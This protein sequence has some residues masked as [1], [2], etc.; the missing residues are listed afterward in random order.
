MQPI[1]PE[2]ADPGRSGLI[3]RRDV[4]IGTL[5][6]FASGCGIG[7]RIPGGNIV[8]DDRDTEA[9]SPAPEEP[10]R[11][12]ENLV[13]LAED[14]TDIVDE[15]QDTRFL[16]EVWEND[17]NLNPQYRGAYLESLP[18]DTGEPLLHSNMTLDEF[19]GA[20]ETWFAA[21][22]T[23]VKIDEITGGIVDNTDT[24][25]RFFNGITVNALANP[26][27]L[28]PNDADAD[29]KAL[30]TF[31]DRLRAAYKTSLRTPNDGLTRGWQSFMGN[32]LEMSG[33]KGENP[34]DW[35]IAF[36]PNINKLSAEQQ[37]A[38]MAQ[39]TIDAALD[40]YGELLPGETLQWETFLR[41]TKGREEFMFLNWDGEYE[42]VAFIAGFVGR[43]TAQARD[44]GDGYAL[45]L[46]QT[47]TKRGK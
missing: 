9:Q 45:R 12:E 26:A 25:K 44:V 18:P 39:P 16:H 46:G 33:L 13:N 35:K 31:I 38:F 34:S 23:S 1:S 4:L 5:A 15:P 40:Y 17:A 10:A 28:D 20:M 24:D 43:H 27:D 36:G 22:A 32:V 6:A 37:A 41:N 21:S 11:S 30:E 47:E 14:T 19:T 29:R 8:G 42:P 2:K 7:P 3:P